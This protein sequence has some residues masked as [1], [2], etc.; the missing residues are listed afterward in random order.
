MGKSTLSDR[1]GRLLSIT[2]L[3]QDDCGGKAAV[4]LPRLQAL[5]TAQ[6]AAI[7]DRYG[8]HGPLRPPGPCT[9]MAT[10]SRRIGGAC[11]PQKQP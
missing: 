4:F 5:L 8:P 6:G 1:L 7:A 9:L 3:S 2:R 10:L 11:V